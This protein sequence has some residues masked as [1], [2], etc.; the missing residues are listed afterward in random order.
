MRRKRT[1]PPETL[2]GALT[3]NRLLLTDT[4]SLSRAEVTLMSVTSFSTCS[5][6]IDFLYIVSIMK[7][8]RA[9]HALPEK[10]D[11]K[12]CA[13]NGM[14]CRNTR[15]KFSQMVTARRRYSKADGESPP[16]A[17]WGTVLE[18]ASI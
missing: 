13:E 18:K 7:V 1:G 10:A 9:K 8:S 4:D 3:I 14:N 5:Q 11:G 15:K 17:E 12:Q 16:S 2:F 6:S